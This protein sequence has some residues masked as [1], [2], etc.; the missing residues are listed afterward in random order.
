M[1]S[2]LYSSSQVSLFEV[3]NPT[4]SLN[5]REAEVNMQIHAKTS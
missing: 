1:Q 2:Q 5:T 3:A 4:P